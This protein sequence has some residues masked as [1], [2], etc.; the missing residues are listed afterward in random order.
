MNT[1]NANKRT[2][3]TGFSDISVYTSPKP[4]IF[5]KYVPGCDRDFTDEVTDCPLMGWAE[6]NQ[7]HFGRFY[8]LHD[9]IFYCWRCDDSTHLRRCP[10]LTF[11]FNN[12]EA[13][14]ESVT[15]PPF[16]PTNNIISD[17]IT[18]L[19]WFISE[20]IVT[21]TDGDIRQEH[22]RFLFYTYHETACSRILSNSGIL[23]MS[24]ILHKEL[25]DKGLRKDCLYDYK[26][27]ADLYNLAAVTLSQKA[28]EF[29]LETQQRAQEQGWI[30]IS[31]GMI[32]ARLFEVKQAAANLRSK[33]A[34]IDGFLQAES[35]NKKQNSESVLNWKI[36]EIKDMIIVEIKK[37]M[38]H[39]NT[40]AKAVDNVLKRFPELK[41][42][43][44]RAIRQEYTRRKKPKKR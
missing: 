14:I 15:K 31:A 7:S 24:A 43:S 8:P 25:S 26:Q 2:L 21:P 10:L 23:P 37:E 36:P 30:D 27:L 11:R 41:Y 19:G 34:D 17:L 3:L 40:L 6:R 32:N 4:K 16:I 18:L 12:D 28:S 5:C 42:T 44:V 22:N 33:L 20:P 35:Q 13:L 1:D 9:P 29:D 39:V 38:G